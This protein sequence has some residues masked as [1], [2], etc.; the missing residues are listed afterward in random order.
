[1][2]QKITKA[3][4]LQIN[5]SLKSFCEKTLNFCEIAK[6]SCDNKVTILQNCATKD[7]IS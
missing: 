2:C 4:S 6:K 1:M 7:A 5:L 3:D